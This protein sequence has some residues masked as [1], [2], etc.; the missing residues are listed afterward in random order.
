M[1]PHRIWARGELHTG[2]WWRKLRERDSLERPRRRWEDNV[3]VDMIKISWKGL[4]WIY[5]AQN[6]AEPGKLL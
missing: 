4:N 6:G 1:N 5:V 3:K 2:L